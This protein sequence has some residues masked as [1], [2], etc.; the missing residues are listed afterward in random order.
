[1]FLT[2]HFPEKIPRE[3]GRKTPRE[4]LES[5]KIQNKLN[6]DPDP[7]QRNG[8]LQGSRPAPNR[9][10][11][12]DQS[13]VQE[14]S[15]PVP[16]GQAFAI[17]E[18]RSGKCHTSI[19]AGLRGLRGSDGRSQARRLQFPAELRRRHRKQLLFSV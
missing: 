13:G 9:D 2:R 17:A 11:G 1:M 10:Q 15:V 18:G 3:R 5:T 6:P 4:T 7:I 12:R 8:S 19:Q 16:P 14:A